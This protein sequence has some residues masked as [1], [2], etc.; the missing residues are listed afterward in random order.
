MV[1]LLLSFLLQHPDV[2][3]NAGKTL[4]APRLVNTASMQESFADMA[5]SILGCYRGLRHRWTMNAGNR[6]PRYTTAW[7]ELP[8]EQA[9]DSRLGLHHF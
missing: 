5:K 7:A 2:V 1:S 8:V 4:S 6:T 9:K 3:A